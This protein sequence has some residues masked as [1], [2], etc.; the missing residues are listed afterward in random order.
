VGRARS[1]VVLVEVLRCIRVP[2]G[3]RRHGRELQVESD[4]RFH[5]DGP[6]AN[7]DKDSYGGHPWSL[8]RETGTGCVFGT[9]ISRGLHGWTDGVALVAMSVA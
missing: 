1:V 3:R 9:S 8:R 5:D 6:G 7:P 2:S 4:E